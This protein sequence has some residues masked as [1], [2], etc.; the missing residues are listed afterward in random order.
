[1]RLME[2]GRGR[3][4]PLDDRTL[5]PTGTWEHVEDVKGGQPDGG[6]QAGLARGTPL[7]H[8]AWE[9]STDERWRLV[10]RGAVQ[11]DGCSTTGREGGGKKKAQ[12]DR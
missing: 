12:R 4:G 9:G 3:K 10:G 11:V 7:G 5:G 1:M 2:T 6:R 8:L